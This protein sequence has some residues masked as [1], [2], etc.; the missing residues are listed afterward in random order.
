MD[1]EEQPAP[2]GANAAEPTLSYPFHRPSAIEVPPLYAE[3]RESCPVAHVRLPSGDPGHVVTRYDDVRTVLADPRFSRAATVAPGAPQLSSTPPLA[4]GLFTMDPPEHTRLRKLVLREFTGRRVQRLRPR[5]QELTDGLLDSMD[6]LAPPVDLNTELAFPLPV[7]VI[8]EL[9]GVP[10]EDRGRFRAWSDAF[11]SLTSHT[12][13]E[14][15]VQRSSMIAYLAALIQRKREEPTDDLIGA[16][17]AAHDDEG[18][19]TEHELIT[20]C[21]TLLVAG[22]ETTVSMIGTCVLT[23]LRHPEHLA[24]LRENPDM[25]EHAV[26]ELMRINPI[27]DG[28]PLRVTLEDVELG[29]TLIPKG[30]AVLAA[31]CSANQDAARFPEGSPADFDPR[32]PSA[33]QHVA[34]GHGPHHCLGAA[35]ARA[36]LQIVIGSLLRRFPALKLAE[37]VAD[38]R[39][40]TG[41]MVHGLTRLPVTW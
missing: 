5:I 22:H 35:L 37:D 17:V 34:F 26:E 14:T 15:A 28:G 36:E 9:L 3:L 39:M 8:C 31:I 33:N 4:G 20:M 18:R 2:S 13:E 12:P 16:L 41:M 1:V 29:G 21:I 25:I 40:T 24:A 30:S 7:M 23:L 27:G 38:L 32:R 6:R 11:V 19:L 10:F